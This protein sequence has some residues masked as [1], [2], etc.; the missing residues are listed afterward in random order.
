[1]LSHEITSITG[2]NKKRKRVGRGVGSGHGKTCGRG[3]KGSLSRAGAGGKLGYEGGSMPLFR[4]LPKRGFNNFN[5]ACK[6][7]VVN[8]SQL[9]RFD[10]GASIDAKALFNAG[11]VNSVRSRIKVLGDGEL[12]KKLL[13]TVHKYSKTAQDKIIS[14]GGEA[15][16]VA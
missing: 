7:E 9:D 12:T 8:V 16:I 5:F 6:Y 13:V 2:G 1:M 10:N 14:C 3:H 15:K 11:L 4:R